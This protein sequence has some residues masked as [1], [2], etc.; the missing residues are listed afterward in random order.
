MKKDPIL[1]RKEYKENGNSMLLVVNGGLHY[2]MGNSTPYFSITA[3]L[4][5]NRRNI[6]GG[7]LHDDIERQFPGQF[8]DLIALHLSDM[9]GVPMHFIANGWYFLAGALGGAGERYHFGAD[10]SPSECLKTFS[11]HCRIDLAEAQRIADDV[12]ASFGPESESGP[13]HSSADYARGRKL[14]SGIAATMESRFRQEAKDCIARHNL[15]I[16]GD[17]YEVAA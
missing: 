7:C 1:A 16:F 5:E 8:S 11:E 4:Y 15:Q 6:A 12:K 17:K 14:W 10:K 3:T 13:I 2:M 9:S